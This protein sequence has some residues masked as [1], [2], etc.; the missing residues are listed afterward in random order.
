MS[1]VH[2]AEC[3]YFTLAASSSFVLAPSAL[4]PAVSPSNKGESKAHCISLIDRCCCNVSCCC[5]DFYSLLCLFQPLKRE[6]LTSCRKSSRTA[7]LDLLLVLGK[8]TSTIR[9]TVFTAP[10][11]SST[12]LHTA[13]R[14]VCMHTDKNRPF[15]RS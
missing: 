5:C 14:V 1:S 15:D 3:Q 7:E 2:T 9:L 11:S 10:C 6:T 12:N 4:G 13:C 8:S